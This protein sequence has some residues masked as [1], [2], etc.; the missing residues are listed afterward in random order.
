[1]AFSIDVLC[2][3]GIAAG[4][5]LAAHTTVSAAP[6]PERSVLVSAK[7]AAA[8]RECNGKAA[9]FVH[10]TWGVGQDHCYRACMAQHRERE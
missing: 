6:K 2:R 1:M 7:R 10:Y 9:R 3:A 8:L 5:I 4:L